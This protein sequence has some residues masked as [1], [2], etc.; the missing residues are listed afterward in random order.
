MRYCSSAIANSWY[1][2]EMSGSDR[3]YKVNSKRT[4]AIAYGR[5][6]RHRV[7]IL[8]KQQGFC[9]ETSIPSLFN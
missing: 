4:F 3:Y 2:Q 9:R 7:L 5:R 1:R 6:L 8:L